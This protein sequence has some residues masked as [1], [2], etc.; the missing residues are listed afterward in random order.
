ME[1][2]K[3]KAMIFSID[4]VLTIRIYVNILNIKNKYLLE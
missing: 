3:E 2:I 4:I 1:K